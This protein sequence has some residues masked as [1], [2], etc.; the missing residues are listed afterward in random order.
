MLTNLDVLQKLFSIIQVILVVLPIPGYIHPDEFFQ[1]SEVMASDILHFKSVKTWEWNI[2]KPSRNIVFP[3][4]S[5]GM[6]F[7]L[8][9]TLN[10][11]FGLAYS[12]NM[13]LVLPRCFMLVMIYLIEII[14]VKYLQLQCPDIKQPRGRN[15]DKAEG[16]KDGVEDVA[17]FKLLFRS[18]HVTLVFMIRTF[19]NTVETF[20]YILTMYIIKKMHLK[21]NDGNYIIDKFTLGLIFSFGFF[22]RPSFVAFFLAASI[23]HGIHLVAL[24]PM[25]QAIQKGMNFN[26]FLIVGFIIGGTFNIFVDNYY[27]GTQNEVTP[28]NLIEYNADINNLNHHGIHPRFLHFIVNMMLLFGPIYIIF[29]LVS[30]KTVLSCMQQADGVSSFFRYLKSKE[31]LLLTVVPVCIMSFIPHQEPRYIIPVII[32]LLFSTIPIIKQ[33]AADKKLFWIVW[34][35]FNLIGVVWYGFLHQGGLIPALTRI[36][37][38]VTNRNKTMSVENHFIFW[39][40]Y[41]VPR[42]LSSFHKD[43]EAFSVYDLSGS[44]VENVT[45]TIKQITTQ[46]SCAKQIYLLAPSSIQKELME[47]LQSPFQLVE[48]FYPHI[49]LEDFPAVQMKDFISKFH[50]WSIKELRDIATDCFS[51]NM[52]LLQ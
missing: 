43:D 29:I 45:F 42:H 15:T 20:L 23:T 8:I 47:K 28:L 16:L 4:M 52:Y 21:S 33:K 5:C 34:F 32:P 38:N 7:W 46:S 17:I 48:Q 36:S 49:T 10:E 9:R 27:F 50:S 18:S 13:L 3:F 6:P 24:N 25:L 26:I 2:T 19:S 35:L 30:F 41:L 37:Q 22:I 31:V 12:A 11:Y 39:K 40:T 1:C 44:G 51:L 14:A